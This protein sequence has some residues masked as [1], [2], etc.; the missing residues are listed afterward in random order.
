MAVDGVAD[1]IELT[2]VHTNFDADTFFPEIN[3][4]EW[5]YGGGTPRRRKTHI[6]FYV[7][8]ISK[9]II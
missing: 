1:E 4:H 3:P 5:K 8:T 2:R 7:F 6:R 9:N